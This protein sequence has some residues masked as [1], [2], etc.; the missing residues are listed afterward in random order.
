MLRATDHARLLLAP[1]IKSGDWVVDATVGNGHDTLWLAERVG[2]AGRVYGFDVQAAALETAT[3]RLV[4]Q[5]HIT[6]VLA[7]H[8]HMAAELPADARDRIVVVM[9]NLGYLPGASKAVTT[10]AATT[11]AALEQ[12]LGLIGVGGMISLVLYPGHAGG[13]LEAAAVRSWM[14]T[15]PVQFAASH[16]V[17]MNALEAAPELVVIERLK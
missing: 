17:R 10:R 5:P 8:E 14:Q 13:A 3:E 9:F 7:G 4:G 1:R 12:A 15:V 16:C 2:A 11:I 6:L